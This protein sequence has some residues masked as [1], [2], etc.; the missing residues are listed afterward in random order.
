[1]NVVSVTPVSKELIIYVSLTHPKMP[2]DVE[3]RRHVS[4][5]LIKGNG[6]GASLLGRQTAVGVS[7]PWWVTGGVDAK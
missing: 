6:L 1:V 3:M 4:I 5:F 2:D 7:T